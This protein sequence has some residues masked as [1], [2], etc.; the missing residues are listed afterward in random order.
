LSWDAESLCST[1][2]LREGEYQLRKRR[3]PRHRG[4]SPLDTFF[5][6]RDVIRDAETI[7]S[8]SPSTNNG[9]ATGASEDE[10]TRDLRRENSELRSTL[11]DLKA[12]VK[13]AYNARDNQEAEATRLRQE[14]EATRQNKEGEV[15]RL[16]AE[17]RKLQSEFTFSSQSCSIEADVFCRR[18]V[19]H[20]VHSSIPLSSSSNKT[21][22]VIQ[23]LSK[24]VKDLGK[25][26]KEKNEQLGTLSTSSILLSYSRLIVFVHQMTAE[27]MIEM[28][29]SG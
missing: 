18:A 28:T 14:I 10:E 2:Y 20:G 9:D 6:P 13:E 29:R 15:E 8:T 1:I 22:Y 26:L 16:K 17:N 21:G 3:V 12:E 25:Q 7:M 19:S 23:A 11:D 24:Q 4:R 27:L 5:E